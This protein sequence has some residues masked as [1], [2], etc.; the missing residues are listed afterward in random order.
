MSQSDVINIMAKDGTN[1][2]VWGSVTGATAPAFS[3]QP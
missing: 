1:W 2:Y 3:D